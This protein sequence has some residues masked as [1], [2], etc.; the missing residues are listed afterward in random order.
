[1]RKYSFQD[2]IVLVNG[3]EITGWAEGDDVIQLARLGDSA[4]HIIGADGEMVVS[5]SADR[6]GTM[7]LTL[8]QAS[9]S[10]LY[11][12]GLIAVQ[13]N[14]AF[15][16]VFVQFKDTGGNDIGSGTQGYLTKPADM[17]RGVGINNQEWVIVVER[18]D[19]LHGGSDIVT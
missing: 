12:A 17:T 9:D 5:L 16:P 18:L 3:I 19:L 7:T 13:E 15:V 1:M 2:T 8:Q 14:G 4:S 11:L 10:N 6:S